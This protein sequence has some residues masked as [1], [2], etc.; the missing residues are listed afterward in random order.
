MKA[1]LSILGL[2]NYDTSIFENFVV[3]EGVDAALAI[4]TLVIDNAELEIV[5]PEPDFLKLIIGQW[6]TKELP[7]W[8]RIYKASQ[9]EYNPIENYNRTESWTDTESEETAAENTASSTEQN[10]VSA[11]NSAAYSPKDK[12]TGI[13][14]NSGTGSR[15][16]TASHTGNVSGNIGVTTSQQ[17]LEQELAIA[18]KLD[19][20]Q[21][22]SESFKRRFC[23]MVY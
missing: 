3:P 14:S 22:I 2:Y 21:Y 10:D 12:T 1:T 6:S 9:L 11:F 17:M 5:Y 4:N 13:G 8:D 20:Y 16:R 23:L 18:P 15:E 7:I 19:I